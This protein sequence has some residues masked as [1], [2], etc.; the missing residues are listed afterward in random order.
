MRES[1]GGANVRP[2]G[3]VD[4]HLLPSMTPKG[5]RARHLSLGGGGEVTGSRMRSIVTRYSNL[6]DASVHNAAKRLWTEHGPRLHGVVMGGTKPGKDPGKVPTTMGWNVSPAPLTAVQA[7]VEAGWPVGIVPILGRGG[8]QMIAFDFDWKE[9]DELTREAF[10]AQCWNHFDPN[11]AVILDSPTPGRWHLF[12]RVS[13]R[14]ADVKFPDKARWKGGVEVEVKHKANHCITIWNTTD[15]FVAIMG[16][17][18]QDEGVMW[19]MSMLMHKAKQVGDATMPTN[20]AFPSGAVMPT[21]ASLPKEQLPAFLQA[22]IDAGEGLPAPTLLSLGSEDAASEVDRKDLPSFERIVSQCPELARAVADGGGND[23]EYFRVVVAGLS[24]FC[25]DGRQKMR[26]VAERHPNVNAPHFRDGNEALFD[27]W[28][29]K[30]PNCDTINEVSL[31]E[32]GTGCKATCPHHATGKCPFKSP[33]ALGYGPRE[34]DAP[35]LKGQVVTNELSGAREVESI[36]QACDFVGIEPYHDHFTQQVIF[37]RRDLEGYPWE[38]WQKRTVTLAQSRAESRCTVPNG[39]GKRKKPV[40]GDAKFPTLLDSL[41]DKSFEARHVNIAAE[42]VKAEVPPEVCTLEDYEFMRQSPMN[43]WGAVTR[44]EFERDINMRMFEQMGVNMFD[45]AYNPGCLLRTNLVM[46]GEG[47][48]AK[49]TWLHYIL[50]EQMR[51]FR[52]FGGSFPLMGTLER[53][54]KEQAGYLLVEYA[55][56]EK[57][58]KG[59]SAGNV[60][61]FLTMTDQGARNLYDDRRTHYQITAAGVGTANVDDKPFP[62]VREIKTRL[63]HVHV[64]KNPWEGKN[65]EHE[66]RTTDFRQRMWRGWGYAYYHLERRGMQGLGAMTEGV[67]KRVAEHVFQPSDLEDT[68][69]ELLDN[70]QERMDRGEVGHPDIFWRG[71]RSPDI[72]NALTNINP[73][74]PKEATTKFGN[75]IEKLGFIK[76]VNDGKR[77]HRWVHEE[78]YNRAKQIGFQPK[79]NRGDI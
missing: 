17:P 40:F 75:K 31:V 77:G 74:L 72:V 62:D 41:G 16:G 51:E 36:V 6:H 26:D 25:E 69:N 23:R 29:A 70:A 30:P 44:D 5:E 22:K 65:I 43:L 66:M 12:C 33:I 4:L 79:V 18:A 54:V 42:M 20:A 27:T 13:P 68:L 9:G 73:N 15:S 37:R 50:L 34:A 24:R 39:P 53:M 61:D 46:I 56:I 60:K 21:A 28:G 32:R 57:I 64:T 52:M 71:A 45:R 49:T 63:V 59:E 47:E 7:E 48:K 35:N 58:R 67:L 1:A 10:E 2:S 78:L 19:V 8:T 11:G 55:E 14:L 76:V 3:A 38:K